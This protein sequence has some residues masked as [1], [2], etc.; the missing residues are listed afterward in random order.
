MMTPRII[1]VFPRRTR[2]T[3]DDALVYFGPP[4]R[5]AEADE[6]YSSCVVHFRRSS[7]ARSNNRSN[8][9]FRSVC[10][11]AS[12]SP[13]TSP[14]PSEFAPP[15]RIRQ[16]GR[17]RADPFGVIG[18]VRAI[19]KARHPFI[20]FSVWRLRPRSMRHWCVQW[21]NGPLEAEIEELVR[22]FARKDLT[23]RLD[24]KSDPEP[25]RSEG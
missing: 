22:P 12:R 15:R 24:P 21:T 2:A 7:C 25:R 9:K 16:F 13:G 11:S 14:R 20:R 5:L 10:T 4:D 1:R 8:W 17:P 3:P 18:Q 19:L 6:V 23:F